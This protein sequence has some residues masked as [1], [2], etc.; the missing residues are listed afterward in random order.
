MTILYIVPKPLNQIC[1]SAQQKGPSVGIL[2]GKKI[3]FYKAAQNFLKKNFWGEFAYK[4]SL[5]CIH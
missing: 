2:I 3:R 4:Y 1:V 5:L